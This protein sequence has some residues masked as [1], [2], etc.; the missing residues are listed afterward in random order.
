MTLTHRLILSLT[1]TTSLASADPV[2]DLA[3]HNR[4]LHVLDIWIRDPYVTTGPDGLFYLTGTQP[5]RDD[6]RWPQ[7]RYN[8]G[9]DNPIGKPGA[10]PSIV[11]REVRVWRSANLLDWTELPETFT[12]DQGFWAQKS[13]APF[14]TVPPADW[15]LW[16]PEISW[17]DGKAVIVHTSPAPVRGG[18]NL[19]VSADAGLSAPYTHPMGDLMR[20]RHDPSLFTDPADGTV[21]LLWGNT[22]IAP[23]K[24]DF[25][26]FA[27]EPVRIDPSDRVIGHEGATMAKIG[28]KYVHFGTAWSTDQLRKGSYNLYYC[29][30]DSPL[31]PFGPRQ[32]AGRFL[33]HGTPFQDH[34]GRWW[35]T[36]FYNA[37][38]PPVSAE[39]I[40]TRNLGDDA[41]TIN[42]QG[43]TLVP[44]DVRVLA[45]GEIHIRA[46]DPRYAVPGPDEVQ[47]FG[48][49]PVTAALAAHDRAVHIHDHWIRDPYITLVDDWYYLT[50]TTLL[51][52]NPAESGIYAWRSRDLANWEP[53]PRLWQFSDTAWIDLQQPVQHHVGQLLVWAPELHRIGDRWVI[54]TT[55]NNR[56]ANLLTT[57]GPA[58]TGPLAEPMGAAFGHHHD[59]SIFVAD[60]GTP[61]LVDGILSLRPLQ[62]DFSGFAGDEIRLNPADR[63]M[64]HEGSYI[65]KV[66]A[67]YVWF[68]TAW[69]TDQPRKGTYNLYYATA[70]ALTGPYGR[71]RFAGRF[72]GHGTPFQDKQGRWWCTAFFNANHPPVAAAQAHDAFPDDAYTLNRQGTTLVPLE[73]TTDAAGEVWVRAK[74]PAY[75][76]PGPEEAQT[77]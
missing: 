28:D 62:R 26:G 18:A 22:H 60:D 7:D 19:A 68:G 24:P 35:C 1:L 56:F 66:G 69:S 58:L 29:T 13:P 65:I 70:D 73:I 46:K 40:Q 21:Y 31:G 10:P 32:F 2:A 57:A 45:D 36:A 67:K 47:D 11:G 64:G 14:A 17:H 25:S 20:G 41:Q 3:A 4:A 48:L 8:A 77:F 33:G 72:L 55:T 54:V 9:L 44:L 75:A 12:M 15:R 37:N 34:E 27:A 53:L 42:E 5:N 74:D 76:K 63:R 61:W 52:V 71:R 38:V 51:T 59:P 50:G 49:H 39:N 6:P 30:A 23:L 43:V 16:A